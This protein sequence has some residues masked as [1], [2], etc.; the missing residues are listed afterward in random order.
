MKRSTSFNII[1]P[2]N[3]N[4]GWR[5]KKSGE[6]DPCSYE[7]LKAVKFVKTLHP[8]ISF[9]KSKSLK[10]TVEFAKNK[11]HIPGAGNYK[12]EK[13]FDTISR[14]YMKKRY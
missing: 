12:V 3:E 14:P 8:K 5:P 10:F 11:K 7:V 6:P 1:K 13:C 9:P 2:I 4:K